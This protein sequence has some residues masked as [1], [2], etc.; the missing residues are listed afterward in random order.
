METEKM[1]EKVKDT[2]E[3]IIKEITKKPNITPADLDHLTKSVC[4]VEKIR[5][6][7]EGTDGGNSNSYDGGSSY[8]RGR[9]SVTG[10]YVSRDGGSSSYNSGYYNDEGMY[11]DGGGGSSRDGGSS[12]RRY[13]DGGSNSSRNSGYSGHSMRDRAVAKLEEMYDEARTEH[14]R[15]FLNDMINR[16]Q[17]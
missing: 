10:R 12:H 2:V 1:L 15:R 7:E 6:I 17:G 11:H 14:E 13:Y 9:S 5:T 3:D 8:R 16:L 4:L